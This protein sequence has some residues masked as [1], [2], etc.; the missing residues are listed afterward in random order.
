M[1]RW[2]QGVWAAV[3]LGACGPVSGSGDAGIDA[4]ID[5]A[6]AD[7]P[8]A[9]A[10][11]GTGAILGRVRAVGATNGLGGV[12]VRRAGG[13]EVVSDA[14]GYFVFAAVPE[15]PRA[16]VI[17]DHPGY[18]PAIEPVEVEAGAVSE[19]DVV[20][21]R[22][23]A[24]AQ[25]DPSVGGRV[26]D[27][28]GGVALIPAN[29]LVTADGR[30][31]TGMVTVSIAP[32]D[33]SDDAQMSAFPGDFTATRS[34]GS[35][36]DLETF[37]PM[38]VTAR[39]GSATLELAS[40][41]SAELSLPV[42]AA[43]TARAPETIELWRLD[44]ATGQWREEGTAQRATAPN[45]QGRVI[46]RAA[47]RRLGWWNCDRPT[48]TTCVRGCVR[49]PDGRP[50][51]RA[52]VSGRGLDYYGS[53]SAVTSPATGCF[54]MDVKRAARVEIRASSGGLSSAARAVMSGD[55]VMRAASARERCL[56]LGVI[57]LAAPVPNPCAAAMSLCGERCTDLARDNANCGACGN[58]CSAG[59][60][61][62]S[63]TCAGFD[64]GTDVPRDT[65]ADV[66]RD[67][68]T[69]VPRDAGVDSGPR[70][71]EGRTY[72]VADCVDLATSVANCGA[73]ENVCAGG[74]NGV[75]SCTGRVCGLQCFAGFGDCDRD[76][77]NGCETVL[78]ASAQHCGACGSACVAPGGGTASCVMGRCQ[79]A[80]ATGRTLCGGACVDVQSDAANCGT[81]G[82]ACA[83]GRTCA[84]GACVAPET[85]FRVTSLTA[86]RCAR[87]EHSALSGSSAGGIAVGGEQ[88]I[89]AGSTGTARF[90]LGLTRAT[91]N[92]TRYPALLG[93][94]N[95][96]VFT[97][98]VGSS[99]LGATGGVAD[100]LLEINA[101]G[102]LNGRRVALSTPLT[103]T[104]GTGFFA[105][106]NRVMIYAGGR[107]YDIE[108]A[109]GRV[110][111]R[112]ALALPAHPTCG[113]LG[114]WGTAEN[115]LGQYYLDLVQ[116]RTTIARVRVSDGQVTPLATFSDLGS[117]CAFT[118]WYGQWFIASDGP[119]DFAPTATVGASHVVG[120][121]AATDAPIV[122]SGASV[123]AGQNF[124]C[125]LR[126]DA[127]VACWGTNS[128]G[129]LGDNTTVTPRLAP[130][131][132][133]GGVGAVSVVAGANHACALQ[134]TGRVLCWGDNSAGQLGSNSTTSRRFAGAVVGL[135][136][137]VAIAA[138]ATHT[139]A[140]LAT[141][142]VVCW[143]S[144]LAGQLGDGTT[145]PRW[146]PTAVAGLTDAV[147]IAAGTSH[148]CAIRAGG[149]VVCWG[150]NSV[151]QVGDGT[152]VNQVRPSAVGGLFE[153]SSLAA[154]QDFTCARWGGGF[155]SCWGSNLAG[156]IGDG[157]SV[158]RPAPTQITGLVNVAGIAAGGQHACALTGGNTAVCWGNTAIGD[159]AAI[160]RRS[161][162]EVSGLGMV[163]ELSA[164]NDQ[165]CA[166]LATGA[167]LCWGENVTGQ[168]G[169]GSTTRRLTPVAVA[170]L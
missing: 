19:V 113:G 105:G 49:A 142:G 167:V 50:F 118:V 156:Q 4:G 135:S 31:A 133:Q 138:G 17:I 140:R 75:P 96:A 168:L 8:D 67:A 123:A 116:N 58:I 80:C 128:L 144:N 103:I 35:A 57:E 150:G 1:R 154:G 92:A 52:R 24:S 54:A 82:S 64:A 88:V 70:C 25:I 121:A 139:C 165:S 100:G 27:G 117:S 53:S 131:A 11:R 130:V 169:D 115:Y 10:P 41:M 83:A 12:T 166:R 155:V 61:C 159:G 39:Q 42:P 3:A 48:E 98:G 124:T 160:L 74:T 107:V 158:N 77:G 59:R 106:F 62:V 66:P 22:Y 126:A 134:A 85:P 84:A 132:V 145:T 127:S 93:T 125:A 114:F 6:V 141:G 170:G 157:T 45:P 152:T 71:S 89:H 21:V 73:C 15:D 44:P 147:A 63:G 34:D 87:Q 91:L 108:V 20:L 36:T 95:G 137:A 33:P 161:P 136:N 13:S 164:G 68:G 94:V 99:A 163:R 5:G 16:T 119:S 97:L 86:T 112:G 47:V 2:W 149:T 104:P 28:A 129:Q 56:D 90:D 26:D 29:A 7:A 30:P 122:L 79:T 51:P 143:G 148:T 153:V 40:G 146:V 69:D 162:V 55:A 14:N 65:G 9:V 111:D 38:V 32:L 60:S 72:C 76:R 81:C 43:A 18:A 109:T 102:A 110:T 151:G 46:Y 101:E 120:C 23:T 37:V 78:M